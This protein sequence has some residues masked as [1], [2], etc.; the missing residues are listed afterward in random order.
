MGFH[1]CK[2]PSTE[3]QPVLLGCL[4]LSDQFFRANTVSK[5]LN[6]LQCEMANLDLT[7]FGY[8]ILTI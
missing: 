6:E 1:L 2:S 3:I 7:L 8:D 5:V 4:R